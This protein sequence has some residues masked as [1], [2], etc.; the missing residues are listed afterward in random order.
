VTRARRVRISHP[1]WI[2]PAQGRVQ[3]SLCFFTGAS[4]SCPPVADVTQNGASIAVSLH[5]NHEIVLTGI[6]SDSVQQVTAVFADGS[7]QVINA[8]DNFLWAT[9]PHGPKEVDWIGPD[10]PQ[11]VHLP[12]QFS[13][14]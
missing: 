14:L 3:H 1:A 11:V 8:A 10:G 6:A 5:A 9:L 12:T 2:A 4:L 7:T 13:Q